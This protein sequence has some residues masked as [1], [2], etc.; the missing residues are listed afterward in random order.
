MACGV[1]KQVAPGVT[2]TCNNAG[3]SSHAGQHTAV[4]SLTAFG[5]VWAT[6]TVRW[7]SA[8]A[9]PHRTKVLQLG[10]GNL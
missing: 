2:A 8:D 4:V 6:T 9:V 10:D 1:T 7:L 3:N 5:R